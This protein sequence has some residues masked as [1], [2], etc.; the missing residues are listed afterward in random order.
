M[1]FE[2][3]WTWLRTQE[4]VKLT[5]A[6]GIPLIAVVSDSSV[7]FRSANDQ[8][9]SV[10]KDRFKKWFHLWFDQGKRNSADFRNESGKKSQAKNL[11][12]VKRLFQL[13]ADQEA[14]IALL[15][16]QAETTA[17]APSITDISSRHPVGADNKP[18]G[19]YAISNTVNAERGSE[20]DGAS[21]L[22]LEILSRHARE[23]VSCSYCFMS[24]REW[25]C[26]QILRR[27][28]DRPDDVP[29]APWI[30][31]RYAMAQPRVAVMMLN[32]GHAAAPH[33]LN[34]KDLNQ[35]LRDG[36]I[37]Y[38]EYNERVAPLV[39]E[40]G[41]RRVAKWL[42]QI[43]LEADKI[44][45]LNAAL[46]A[47][48]D[49][50]YFPEFFETCLERH[51]LRFLVALEPDIVLLCGKDQ[52]TPYKSQIESLGIE[53]ILTWHYRGMSTSRGQAEL[54]R[55]RDELDKVHR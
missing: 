8:D 42:W 15:S 55:V 48:A 7:I 36:R 39:Q 21:T 31:R 28:K 13:I 20:V 54:K 29:V 18:E 47:V 2:C 50:A 37:T 4:H 27:P 11:R 10:S 14:N 23:V 40:W 12:L 26:G 19:G 49:D 34:R 43:N 46:C 30:G 22:K 3:V 1:R 44:A 17:A 41:F 9:R 6:T 51:T 33:K 45:F 25:K 35:L 24:D 16:G 53:V 52:L 38:G 32:P 5:S